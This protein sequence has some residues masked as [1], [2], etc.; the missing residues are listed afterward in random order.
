MN[1]VVGPVRWASL[2][3]LIGLVGAGPASPAR[4]SGLALQDAPYAKPPPGPVRAEGHAVADAGGPF[5]TLGATLFWGGWGYKFDRARLERNLATLSGAGVDYVRVLGSV[6]GAGWEDREIDPRWS[7]YDAVIGGMTD[8][9]YD[10]YGIRVQWTLFGGSPATPAGSSRDAL[11]D[12]FAKLARGREHKI[13]AFEIANE[14]RSNGFPGPDWLAELRSL[15]K[16]LND[17]TSVL[18]TLRAPGA[19]AACDTYADAGA[20][21][22]TIHYERSF[23][24]CASLGSIRLHTTPSAAGSF[25]RSSS[26][27]SPSDQRARFA[28]MPIRRASS[29]VTS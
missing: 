21:A 7:D 15:G 11:V 18:V 14:A 9:A 10:R 5:N 25:R 22:A 12:R 13:F 28:A 17:Q 29:P 3:V 23:G 16:R 6:G 19:G 27:T 1:T 26:T 8:L 20:D 2:I 24:R 4:K